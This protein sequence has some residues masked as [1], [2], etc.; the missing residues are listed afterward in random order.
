MELAPARMACTLAR[1]ELAAA[2]GL[3]AARAV[4]LGPATVPVRGGALTRGRAQGHRRKLLELHRRPTMEEGTKHH[5]RKPPAR[6][7]GHDIM[8]HQREKPTWR[9]IGLSDTAYKVYGPKKPL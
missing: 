8:P 5:R 6:L 3:E 1:E 7:H 9:G 4:K 2:R